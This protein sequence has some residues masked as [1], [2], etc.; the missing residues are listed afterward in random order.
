MILLRYDDPSHTYHIG[1]IVVPSVTQV[2][3]AAEAGT[4]YTRVPV[5]TLE[6]KSAIGS[7]VHSIADLLNTGEWD[8]VRAFEEVGG[9]GGWLHGPLSTAVWDYARGY[10]RFLDEVGPVVESSEL[11]LGSLRHRFAGTLD[12]RL[13]MF[14]SLVLGDIKCTAELNVE[15]VGA[16]TAAYDVLAVEN[17]HARAEER[18][19][20][21]LDGRGDYRLRELRDSRDRLR[22]LDWLDRSR[23]AA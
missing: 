1:D 14:G 16:Q 8:L 11:R 12:V 9:T 17:G 7:A 6:R 4:D 3:A 21:H 2:I 13:R 19:A 10:Q 20:I 22:F 15:A 18:V 5:A 23:L